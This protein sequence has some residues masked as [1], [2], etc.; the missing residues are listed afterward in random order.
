MTSPSLPD[1][2][3]LAAELGD[4]I[5]GYDPLAAD[6]AELHQDGKS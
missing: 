1:L 3:A 2:D 4:S 6:E 5:D